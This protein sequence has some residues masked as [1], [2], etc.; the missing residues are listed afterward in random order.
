MK[1]KYHNI[2]Q[3]INLGSSA[4]LFIEGQFKYL[5]DK[6]Y[7]MHLICSPDNEMENFVNKNSIKYKPVHLSRVLSLWNDIKAF[8]I[9]CKYIKE[10]NIDTVIAHQAKARLLGTTAAFVMHVP[11]RIIFAHGVIFET[12]FGLK[13]KLLILMD[14]IVAA[15]AHKTVCVSKSVAQIRQFYKIEK[16]SQVYYLGAGTCGGI[17]SINNF[18]PERLDLKE[19]LILKTQFGINNNDFIIG[20]CGRLV[21]DKGIIEL[22]EAFKILL[23]HSYRMNLKLFIIGAFEE[24]DGISSDV[25]EYIKKSKQI[26]YVEKVAY[27]QMY[28][29]LALFSVLVLPS[30]REGFGMV[31]IES[32][33]MKVPAIVSKSTGCIDS[34]EEGETGLYCD[35]TP[36]SIAKQID[37][38]INNPTIRYEMGEKARRRV[39]NLYDS[40]V[41]LPYL[42]DVIEV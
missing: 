27:N 34:I 19:Q 23:R 36:D 2:L 33:A 31:T 14:K 13:K 18:N 21:R 39:V 11:N 38:M 1:K 5:R 15:M 28:K 24:R 29:Y 9:I 35:I 4:R 10:N 16:S 6:G 26:I 12:S 8:F 32:A 30:Y 22:I 25:L 42:V 3:I 40:S 17:D 41:V 7:S 37:F 20:F